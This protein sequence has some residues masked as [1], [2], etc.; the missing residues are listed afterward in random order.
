MRTALFI[1]LTLA[2]GTA[3]AA[4]TAPTP[5][6]KRVSYTTPTWSPDGKWLTYTRMEMTP[7]TPPVMAAELYIIHADGTGM[8]RVIGDGEKVAMNPVFSR[9]GK[10]LFFSLMDKRT[11]SG[12]IYSAGI[13]GSEPKKLTTNIYHASSPR[14]SPDGKWIVFNGTLTA[15]AKDHFVQIFLMKSDGTAVKQLTND[16]KISF[17]NPEWSPD[18]KQ[19]V[20]YLE[21]G[22]NK[23]QVWSMN[24]DGSDSK[25][26]TANIG[27]NFYPSWTADGKRIVFTSNRDGKQ[28]LYTMN[29][30][31]SDVKP[32]GIESFAVRYSPDGKRMV[33]AGGQFPNI[34]IFVANADGSNPFQILPSK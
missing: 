26:L 13:S 8:K 11:R 9:D 18:G 4:Q 34:S 31:G 22:D 6:Q 19:L 23:D 2:F 10:T 29:A 25:L 15:D 14:M 33:Y 21:R 27:H 30:D 24:A 32:L 1:V 7:G 17:Y 3:I 12:D 20:Y 16:P 28:Q 5:V